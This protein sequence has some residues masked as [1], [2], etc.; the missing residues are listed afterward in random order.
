MTNNTILLTTPFFPIQTYLNCLLLTY[1]TALPLSN[2]KKHIVN[3]NS[4]PASILTALAKL[5]QTPN[6][7]FLLPAQSCQAVLGKEDTPSSQDYCKIHFLAD[8][9]LFLLSNYR[10]TTINILLKTT[11]IKI[12]LTFFLLWL[13]SIPLKV[14]RT[15][16]IHNTVQVLLYTS[17]KLHQYSRGD[18]RITI[19]ASCKI[20]KLS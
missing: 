4:E 15:Y 2:F 20:Y 12:V 3:S 9:P 16:T 8:P 7:T 11:T 17:V 5:N 6:Q 19:S 14:L 10:N 13:L 1:G 18:E